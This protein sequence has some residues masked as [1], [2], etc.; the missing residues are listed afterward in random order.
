MNPSFTSQM[1]Q[2]CVDSISG[3]V[4]VPLIYYSHIPA[5]VVS[6][7]IGALVIYKKKD[8]VG[9]TLFALSALFSIFVLL[10]LITWLNP[11]TV[12]L[13]FFWSFFGMIISCIFVLCFYFS[14][15]FLFNKDLGTRFKFFILFLLSPIFIIT[16][17]KFGVEYF[18][19]TSCMPIENINFMF[20]YYSFG[21][22]AFIGVI[23]LFFKR[24]LQVKDKEERKINIIFTIGIEFFILMLFFASFFASYLYDLGLVDNYYL[25]LYG[26]FGVII[27]MGALA[28]LIVKFKTFDIKLIATQALV[29]ILLLVIG[30]EFL[31]VTN[32]TGRTL[33]IITFALALGFG[34]FLVRSVKRE[35][36]QREKIEKLA[37][38]L[39]KAN[40]KLRGL[41]KLKSEFLSF[42]SHQLRSPLTAINGYTSMLLEGSFGPLPDKIKK[43]IEVVSNSSK[44][45]IKTVGEFLDISRIEQGGMKYTFTDFDAKELALEV[46]NELK[47]TFESKG[48]SYEFSA[49]EKANY[50]ING[51]KGKIKQIIGNIIDNSGK[52]TPKG[53]IVVKVGKKDGKILISV[54]DTGIGIAKENISKLFAKFSRAKDA[55]NTNVNGTGLGLYVAKKMMEA[56]NGKLWVESSGEGKGSQFYIELNAK[57]A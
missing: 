5:A 57:N 4:N 38:D 56:N 29:V 31:F 39:E 1:Y 2:V 33:V 50:A 15:L 42:A 27:F 20:Y 44:G 23:F 53:G 41:D 7:L 18:D 24:N 34:Y 54:V 37:G 16:P 30:S 17:T 49:D 52:Y 43:P 36:E 32:D 22:L 3:Y 10:S 8:L 9:G 35:I 19:S 55:N 28:Y 14:Y 13:T 45:L 21:I 26:L 40:E 12:A 11:S 25:E 48:L 6:L 51:D 46:F 47:P